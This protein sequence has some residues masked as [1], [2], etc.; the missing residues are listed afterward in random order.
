MSHLRWT[1]PQTV[2]FYLSLWV[3]DRNQK[4]QNKIVV[5]LFF[6]TKIFLGLQSRISVLG[7]IIQEKKGIFITSG[8]LKLKS[9]LYPYNENFMIQIKARYLNVSLFDKVFFCF[10][11]RHSISTS[12][13][14]KWHRLDIIIIIRV[15]EMLISCFTIFLD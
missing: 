3:W 6:A 14:S 5:M 15:W 4:N 11:R 2:Y 12:V 8:S 9:S 7:F 10:F 13:Y 1:N